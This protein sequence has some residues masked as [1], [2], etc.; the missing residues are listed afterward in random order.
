MT[1][2]AKDSEDFDQKTAGSANVYGHVAGP[3]VK[4]LQCLCGL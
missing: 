2:I 3:E 4:N 1:Q